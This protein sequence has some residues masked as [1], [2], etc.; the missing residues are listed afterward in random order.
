MTHHPN[1]V[2]ADALADARNTLVRTA[3]GQ[4]GSD[5]IIIPRAAFDSALRNIDKARAA[6]ATGGAA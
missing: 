1:S 5:D 6:L 4:I 3:T 2:I